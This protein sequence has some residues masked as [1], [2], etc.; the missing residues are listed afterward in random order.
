MMFPESRLKRTLRRHLPWLRTEH[1]LTAAYISQ[2]L[3]RR[4]YVVT[5]RQVARYVTARRTVL[6]SPGFPLASRDFAVTKALI[7]LGVRATRV[8]ESR[9]PE[10]VFA[11]RDSTVVRSDEVASL[12]SVY[13][14][15][16]NAL[17]LDIGKERVEQVHQSVFGYGLAVDPRLG[18]PYLRKSIENAKHDARI[19]DAA[20]EP[21]LGY[22]YQRPLQNRYAEGLFEEIRLPYVG[23]CLPVCIVKLKVDERRFLGMPGLDEIRTVESDELYAVANAVP[24][25]LMFSREEIAQFDR[26][27]REMGLDCGEFDIIRD[28]DNGRLYLIDVNKTAAGPTILLGPRDMSR[29]LDTYAEAVDALLNRFSVN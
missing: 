21:D 6:F 17:C 2:S 18:G 19:F 8:H 5:R 10:A 23:A 25:E 11:W 27:A 16:I 12:V 1:R 26:F 28:G 24:L 7:K 22:V 15:V 3:Y 13:G 4:H 20:A 9:A 29:Y 14:R